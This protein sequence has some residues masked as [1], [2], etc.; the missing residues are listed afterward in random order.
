MVGKNY[1]E[2]SHCQHHMVPRVIFGEG[3]PTHSICP[4]CG[5][6]HQDF[7]PENP[8]TF[9]KDLMCWVGGL[10]NSSQPA[11][12]WVSRLLAVVVVFIAPFSQYGRGWLF[13]IS[14]ILLVI[15]G[16]TS[17]EISPAKRLAKNISDSY[18]KKSP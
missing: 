9:F 7:T 6:L 1:I 12:R 15:Y 16:V 18:K 17:P 5:A 13:I 10:L 11:V 3:V 2:C 4:F 14:I 8:N